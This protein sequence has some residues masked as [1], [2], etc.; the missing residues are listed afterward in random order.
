MS[1]LETAR[2]LPGDLLGGRDMAITALTQ[3]VSMLVSAVESLRADNESIK[4][5]LAD[6]KDR[7]RKVC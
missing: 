1:E 6:I 2:P 5:Q 7:I 4:K 3:T